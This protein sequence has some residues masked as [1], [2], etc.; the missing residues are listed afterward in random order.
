[1][2]VLTAKTV[3]ANHPGRPPKPSAATDMKGTQEQRGEQRG[4]QREE[5]EGG[6]AWVGVLRDE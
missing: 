1:M 3:I 4:E 5:A 6:M 2:D